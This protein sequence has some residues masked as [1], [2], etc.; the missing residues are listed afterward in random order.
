MDT[1]KKIATIFDIDGTLVETAGFEDELY[2]AMVRDVLGDVRIREDWSTYRHV[3]DI[4]V[5]RQVMEE[6]QIHDESRIQDVRAKFGKTVSQYLHDGGECF[7]INGAIGLVDMLH[8]S[9]QYAIGI[10]TGGWGHTA[11]IKLNHAGFDLQ[12]VAIT[13]SDDSEERIK[14]MRK[15]LDALGGS[16]RRI[17]Y[18]GDAEW[19]VQATR[20]LGW[21]FIGVGSRLRGKCENWVED[22]SN[23]ESFMHLLHTR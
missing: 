19:D 14:I 9:D 16:Y 5:L 1:N 20:E 10:A 21:H 15:C 12:D 8:S 4:G 2:I 22:F 23:H 6:N 17:V 3:T 13:S 7:P 18:I 11:R